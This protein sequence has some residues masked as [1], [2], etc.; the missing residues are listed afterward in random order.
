[1]RTRRVP[2]ELNPATH[3]LDLTQGSRWVGELDWI[4]PSSSRRT[5]SKKNRFTALILSKYVAGRFP[6]FHSRSKSRA[7]SRDTQ[8][9][10]RELISSWSCSELAALCT[11]MESACAV[12][13]LV[14]IAEAA[15][16]PVSSL[17]R[18]LLNAFTNCTATDCFVLYK[19]GRYAAHIAVLC[20]RSRYFADLW[21]N[22]RD[23]ASISAIPELTFIDE[24]I[25]HEM[26]LASL[27]YIYS[28]NVPTSVQAA[29]R[30]RFNDLLFRLGCVRSLQDDLVDFDFA[31]KGDCTLI[32]TTN[33][34]A[35]S[36]EEI[37]VRRVDALEYR[38]RCSSA[39]VAARSDFLSS[40]IERKRLRGEPLDIVIDEHLIPR[41]Y[42]PV[43]L[44]AIYTDR[45][46]LSKVLD[47]CQVSASSL[48]EVQAI[49]SGRRQ[50]T[51]LRHAIDVFHI[52][53]FLNL[54][55]LA[56]SCEEVMVAEL[57]MDT[58]GS[59]WEWASEAGG[60]AYVRRQCVAYLRNEFSRICASHVLFEL[61]EQLL[62]DCLVS[63]YVQC[64][65]VEILESIVR[66]GEHELVRRMEEREPNLVANT[67]HSISRRG[68]RRSELD[69][70]ELRN[71][72]G[73]LLPLS[74]N[75]ACK[76]GLLDRSPNADLLG[77][78]YPDSRSPDV[79]PDAHWFDHS[80]PRRHPAGPRLLFPYVTEARSQLRRLCGNGSDILAEYRRGLVSERTRFDRGRLWAHVVNLVPEV[81][82]KQITALVEKRIV[83]TL[84]GSDLIK[85]ALSCGCAHHRDLAIEQVRLRVLRELNLDDNCMQVLLSIPGTAAKD[86][87][88]PRY[89]SSQPALTVMSVW[90]DLMN[91]ACT[92]RPDSPQSE[93]DNESGAEFPPDILCTEAI[94]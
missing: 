24:K 83:E 37:E 67:T 16:P 80:V 3:V 12:R 40:L 21:D 55:R 7:I 62:H 10:F 58:V 15:R 22:M 75:N 73:S 76:R 79:S 88:V 30:H 17:S 65:E 35:A 33:G 39:V 68:V 45:L 59:L 69:D 70:V 26:F 61:D 36:S 60:S 52:A 54:H 53:R 87:Y 38:I 84:Q 19:D 29:E 28:G 1:M 48:N 47:G 9:A 42:A 4:A 11:E 25:P 31:T 93:Y 74:L 89:Y 34:S 82:S 64:S 46:D 57:S 78:R 86:S 18:D 85:K 51:P 44:H 72:L 27:Q 6:R 63:D 5:L 81:L 8:R 2:L 13:E 50:K 43:V 92:S 41:I 32:F 91:N 77:Q 90:P 56:Q 71:I 49:A 66:W 20:A 14:L 23:S 94:I